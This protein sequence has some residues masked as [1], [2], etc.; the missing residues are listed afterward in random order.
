[1]KNIRNRKN[2][3]IASHLTREPIN[4]TGISLLA[5]RGETNQTF[6]SGLLAEI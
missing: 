1:M 6:R 4:K 2:A 5:R 3:L